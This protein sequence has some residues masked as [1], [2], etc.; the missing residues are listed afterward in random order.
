MIK[1]GIKHVYKT[2][3]NFNT[4]D[5]KEISYKEFY[6]VVRLFHRLI[7]SKIIDGY[8]FN[9]EVGTIEIDKKPRPGRMVDWGNSNARKQR[10]IA[11]GKI[12][13][14]KETAP[15]GEHWLCY[16]TDSTHYKWKWNKSA[17]VLGCVLFIACTD[18]K[19]KLGKEVNRKKELE[20]VSFEDLI[21]STHNI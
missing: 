9:S 14:N 17:G 16:F 6:R 1:M 7:S 4:I 8:K 5:K 20:N 3:V 12:P 11:E 2:C 19:K 18:N 21:K 13:F 10:I 15:N